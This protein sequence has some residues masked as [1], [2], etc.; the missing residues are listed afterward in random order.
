MTGG[1]KV[2]TVFQTSV[3]IVSDRFWGVLFKMK[4]SK[5]LLLQYFYYFYPLHKHAVLKKLNI[6]FNEINTMW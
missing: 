4:G 3:L 1:E 2:V 5:Q 6:V